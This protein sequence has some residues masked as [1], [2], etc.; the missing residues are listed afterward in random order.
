MKRII[1]SLW[2]LLFS[3]PIIA[4]NYSDPI[5]LVG[6]SAH[7]ISLAGLTGIS[8]SAVQVLENPASLHPLKRGSISVFSTTLMDEVFYGSIATSIKI[9]NWRFGLGILALSVKDIPK[10]SETFNEFYNEYELTSNSAYSSQKMS[11]KLAIQ[12]SASKDLSYGLS[13][14]HFLSELD[15]VTAS[16]LN[17]DLGLYG[18]LFNSKLSI[19]LRNAV[20]GTYVHYSNNRTESLAYQALIS[21]EIP[22]G[23]SL[24]LYSGLKSIEYK[25]RLN[26]YSVALKYYLPL[27]NNRIS[28]QGGLSQRANHK[29][30]LVLDQ[31]LGLTIA[32]AGLKLH[33][34]VE[35]SEYFLADFNHYFSISISK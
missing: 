29:E 5:D 8:H 20:P 7:S 12:Y 24:V 19:L 34:A 35:H 32:L 28:I 21:S 18:S 14:S 30:T 4:T 1:L 23:S 15:T 16:G 33:Y 11:S 10:T 9:K 3:S 26:L 17:L 25:K 6:S 22:I 13:V 2:I 31:S 27:L